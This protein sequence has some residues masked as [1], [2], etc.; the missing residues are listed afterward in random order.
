[1]GKKTLYLDL[2]GLERIEAAL[3]LLPGRPSLSSFLTDQFPAMADSL[4]QMVLVI[5]SPSATSVSLMAGLNAVAD[6]QLEK[7]V[8][9][10]KMIRD[11]PP[12]EMVSDVPASKP[13][14]QK[15][16]A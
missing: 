13:K 11:I 4:E 12:N 14:R 6:Q 10:K 5:N 7:L 1:M 9:A 3:L 2:D 8:A 16:L 15:K